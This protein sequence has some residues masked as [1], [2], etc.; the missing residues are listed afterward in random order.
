MMAAEQKTAE[1][2]ALRVAAIQQRVEHIE[3]DLRWVKRELR[4]MKNDKT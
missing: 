2:R 3:S 4:K 1:R